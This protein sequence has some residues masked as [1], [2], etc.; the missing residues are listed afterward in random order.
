M[1]S[2][3]VFVLEEQGSLTLPWSMTQHKWPRGIVERKNRIALRN[4]FIMTSLSGTSPIC[5]SNMFHS[6]VCIVSVIF[7]SQ[8]G[9]G[10]GGGDMIMV[11]VKR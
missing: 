7:C 11:A 6:S 9:R 3:Y 8:G 1:F 4:A 5:S 10:G 2:I